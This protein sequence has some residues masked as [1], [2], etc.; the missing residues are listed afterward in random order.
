MK[1]IKCQEQMP[2]ER[3]CQQPTTKVHGL[4]ET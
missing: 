2:E 1:W 4:D 3:K